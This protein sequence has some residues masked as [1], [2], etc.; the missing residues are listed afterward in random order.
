M[1]VEEKVQFTVELEAA[2]ESFKRQLGAVQ[3]LKGELASQYGAKKV[4]L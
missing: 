2:L 4:G 3:V 1:E